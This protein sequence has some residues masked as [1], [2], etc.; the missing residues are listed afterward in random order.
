MADTGF[1]A[2]LQSASEIEISVTGRSSGRTHTYPIWFALDG[3]SS[4]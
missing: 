2:G 1:R 4:I 3:N